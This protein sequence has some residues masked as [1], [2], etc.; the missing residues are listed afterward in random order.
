MKKKKT[1][2]RSSVFMLTVWWFLLCAVVGCLVLC[3][4]PDR[5]RISVDEKRVL[6]NKPPFSFS[7]LVSGEYASAFENFL[8]DSIPGRSALIGLSDRL[9]NT[10][11]FNTAEDLYY[12]DT[13]VDEVLDYQNDMETQPQED[14]NENPGSGDSGEGEESGESSEDAT[15]DLIR[16]DGSRNVIYTYPGQNLRRVADNLD[17]YAALLPEDGQVM[18]TLVPFPGLARRFSDRTDVYKG[19]QSDKFEKIDR[20]TS[21]KVKCFD[22]LQILEPHMLAGENLFLYGNHQWN[23]HGSYYVFCEMIK[24][25]GLTPSPYDEYEYKINRPQNQAYHDLDTYELL[26]P[27]APAKNYRVSKINHRDEF[28]FMSYSKAET[29]AYLYGDLYPWK[30]VVTGFHTGRNALIIGDCFDFPLTPFLLPYYD[31]VHKTDIRYGIFSKERLGTSVAD[32]I[33]RYSIDDVY[34]I[35]SE[36]NDVN[37]TTLR[38]ALAD[39]LY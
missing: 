39:N 2:K 34:M 1:Q 11:S 29:S 8:S 12:L 19:W 3:F 22:A 15:F 33:E 9:L 38:Y 13:S 26:Y 28:P 24:A 36:A 16:T 20:M 31:E 37:S 25:Q 21:D 27:L 32:M 35:F 17:K 30:T 14:E 4:T 6:Q 7:S 10:F 5:E 23:I 18:L